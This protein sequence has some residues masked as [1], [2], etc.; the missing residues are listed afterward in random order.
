M[1]VIYGPEIKACEN[2]QESY[3]NSHLISPFPS[4]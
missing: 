4:V 2:D 1:V 3:E